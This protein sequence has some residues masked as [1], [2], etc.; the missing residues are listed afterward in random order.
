MIEIWKSIKGYEGKYE[1]SNLGRV[2]SLKYNKIMVSAI[3]GG[4]YLGVTLY[5]KEKQKTVH[6]H[7]LVATHFIGNPMMYK[8]VNHKDENKFNNNASN[9]EWCDYRYNNNYGTF[10]ERRA[11]K[12]LKK[13]NQY[14]L[15]GNYIKTFDGIVLATKETGISGKNISSCCTGRRHKA[16]GYAWKFK[17]SEE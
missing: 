11:K 4:G 2:K 10:Q 17:E 13:V 12:R 6:I 3:C 1:I 15:Q 8:C 5:T 9:L 16:G 7:K 14:D